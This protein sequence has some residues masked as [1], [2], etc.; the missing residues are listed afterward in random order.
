MGIQRPDT[1]A[2]NAELKQ[3]SAGIWHVKTKKGQTDAML[4]STLP[5]YFAAVDSPLKTGKEYSVYFELKVLGIRDG[6]SGIAIG[7]AAKPCP[8]WRLPGWHRASV[9]VHGDDGRRFVND[10]WGGRDFVAKFEVGDVVGLGM[11]FETEERGGEKVKTRVSFT[12]NGR[13][14]GGWEADEERDAERDEGIEGLQGEL[15][16]Y[17][18]VGVFGGIEAEIRLRR[19]DWLY[20]SS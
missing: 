5:L 10:S 8:L 12:R 3:T 6:E 17:P 7:Y 19:E 9:G 1:L 13:E 14:E 4:L 15:D 16:M 20:Q 11:K 18:A 2:K